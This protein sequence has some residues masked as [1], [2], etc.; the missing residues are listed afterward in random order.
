MDNFQENLQVM[1]KPYQIQK[2]LIPLD[3]SATSKLALE[4][5]ALICQ[6]FNSKLHLLHVYTGSHAEVLPNIEATNAYMDKSEELKTF[7]TEELNNIGQEFKT[8]Y[9]VDYNIEVREGSISKEIAQTAD[10]IKADLI[11]MGTHGVSGFEEFFLGSNAYRVVTSANMPILTVQEHAQKLGYDSIAL[12]I[13]SS[14]HSRDKVSEA[15]SLAKVFGATIHLAALI[16]SE[17]E[18]EKAIFNLKMKQIED[19]LSDEGIKFTSTTI[20]GKDIAKMTIDFSKEV[21]ADL[22]VVMTEQE[23]AT[24]LFMGPHAQRVVN[25]SPIPVLSVTPL[26]V[27]EGFSQ[28]ELGGD[29]RPFYI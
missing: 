12:P 10:E 14:N 20:H 22:V 25:H 28:K 19:Y 24:G 1:K 9:Q 4:H 11:V 27:I 18:D 7:I 13:D 23:A 29:Y 16:S 21:K 26:A 3:F 15:A 6:K 5:A 17:H 2:I 8:K